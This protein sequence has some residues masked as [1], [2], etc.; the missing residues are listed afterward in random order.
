MGKCILDG[1]TAHWSKSQHDVHLESEVNRHQQWN[2]LAD[3]LY[4][5]VFR[6][7]GLLRADTVMHASVERKFLNVEWL[8]LP[9]RLL[10]YLRT[11]YI[12]TVVKYFYHLTLCVSA[13]LAV[14]R[15]LP[16]VFLSHYTRVLYPKPK[17]EDNRYP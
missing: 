10:F 13:V 15:C 9:Q 3:V 5:L 6:T 4:Q 1:G 12:A 14:G 11:W 2:S 7:T 8:R 16:S 17:N